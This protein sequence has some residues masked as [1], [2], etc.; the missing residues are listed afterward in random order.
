MKTQKALAVLATVSMLGLS[1]ACNGD[2]TT[3]DRY[4]EGLAAGKDQGYKE[5]YDVGYDD[6]YA[7]GD[8]AGYARAKSFFA[9]ADYLKG[10]DDGKA[11][12]TTI[13][14]NNGYAVGKKDGETQGYNNGYNAGKTDGYNQGKREGYDLGYDDGYDDGHWDGGSSSS[15]AYTAGYNAGYSDGKLDGYDEG[16]DVGVNQ[17]YDMGYDD[18]FDDGYDMGYSDGY[19]LSVGKSPRLKGY[20]DVLS[21]FHNDMIDYSQIR[22]PVQTK[23]GLVANGRLLL[24]ETSQTNKDTLKR[25]AAV[26]QYLVVE[27]SK[28][29]KG[30]FGLSAERS[31]KVAK[32]S[33][34]FRKFATKRALTSEDTNAYASEIIGANFSEI[35]KAYEGSL[36]GDLGAFQ[37]VMEKAAAKNEVS[38]EKMASIV[39]QLFI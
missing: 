7:D 6:G 20:A 32:A 28:Q 37:S 38:P 33:N 34:H 36:K 30:K 3:N 15:G 39:T 35:S 11:S 5:G 16:Y 29:I 22:M 18:G 19:G 25:A 8:D 31:L 9:S 12:G 27:M 2:K 1:V 26:E 17:S 10:F 23:R 4:Q 14:Y 24:S 13:G 21:A